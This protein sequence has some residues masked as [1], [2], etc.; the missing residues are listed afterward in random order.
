M[1]LCCLMIKRF[2]GNDVIQ[3]AYMPVVLE[4]LKYVPCSFW[5]E[6]LSELVKF[7]FSHQK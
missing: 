5:D 2:V 7:K 6:V 3:Y 4:Q 1:S